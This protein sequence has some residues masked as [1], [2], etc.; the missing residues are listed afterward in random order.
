M[1]ALQ[2]NLMREGCASVSS[3]QK[4]AGIEVACNSSS[5]DSMW[6]KKI[7]YITSSQIEEQLPDM[8]F[9]VCVDKDMIVHVLSE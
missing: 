8:W 7:F 9:P 6:S 1:D 5:A 4:N 3:I 2:I